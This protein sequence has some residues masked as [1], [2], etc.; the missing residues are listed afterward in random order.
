MWMLK[1][2][3]FGSEDL[4]FGPHLSKNLVFMYPLTQKAGYI[5]H[6]SIQNHILSVYMLGRFEHITPTLRELR[7]SFLSNSAKTAR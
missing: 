3:N 4:L 6:I 2:K 1:L 7:Y 5:R